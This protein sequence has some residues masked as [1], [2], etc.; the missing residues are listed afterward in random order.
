MF[1][2]TG[3][4]P[5]LSVATGMLKVQGVPHSTILSAWHVTSSVRSMLRILFAFVAGS[6]TRSVAANN[7]VGLL[8]IVTGQVAA[9]G[10]TNWSRTP[11][12]I[13]PSGWLVTPLLGSNHATVMVPSG[14]MPKSFVVMPGRE[15]CSTATKRATLVA[16]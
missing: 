7:A 10:P 4:P 13:A 5:Q 15:N 2:V 11:K 1:V 9:A 16:Q 8:S 6:S 12:I 14:K 3:R